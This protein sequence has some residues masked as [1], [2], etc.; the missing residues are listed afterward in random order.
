MGAFPTGRGRGPGR[1]RRRERP[2]RSHPAHTAHDPAWLYDPLQVTEIDLE[3]SQAALAQL[4]AVPD[5]YVDARITLRNGAS[6]YGPY[7][8]GLRLKGH[9]A[10]RSLEGKA[11]FKIKFGYAVRAASTGS[12]E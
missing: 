8:V 3:A 2:T 6:T 7:G 1:C 10:F 11:A 5:E 12:R 4:A 9:G